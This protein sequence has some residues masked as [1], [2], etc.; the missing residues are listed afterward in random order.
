MS[1]TLRSGATSARHDSWIHPRQSGH[2]T[3]APTLSVPPCIARER[4]VGGRPET[5]GFEPFVHHLPM[6][7][8][9]RG[10]Q[11]LAR[12]KSAARVQRSTRAKRETAGRLHATA[13]S[14]SSWREKLEGRGSCLAALST[15]LLPVVIPEAP[16]IPAKALRRDR[17][18]PRGRRASRGSASG[19]TCRTSAS[20]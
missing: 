5:A 12:R 3:R 7:V 2:L 20:K 10:P 19:R 18:S 15:P 11:R 1:R 14:R 13:V 4:R 9:A 17:D 8:A 16:D 6:I